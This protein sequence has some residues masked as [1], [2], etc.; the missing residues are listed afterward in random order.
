MVAR[1][2]Q[3]VKQIYTYFAKSSTHAAELQEMQRVMNEPKLKL[4]RAAETR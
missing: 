3:I 4:K 1:F 2:E